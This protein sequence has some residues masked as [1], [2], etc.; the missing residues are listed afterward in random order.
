M[1]PGLVIR[2]SPLRERLRWLGG[3]IVASIVVLG[4]WLTIET[5]MNGPGV[6]AEIERRNAAEIAE[7]DNAFCSKFG[8]APGTEAFATCARELVHVRQRESAR[9]HRHLNYF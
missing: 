6:W 3:A 8:M 4:G 7:E 5:V 2:N 9:I 1:E